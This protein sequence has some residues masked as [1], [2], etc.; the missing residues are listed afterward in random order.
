MFYCVLYTLGC[1]GKLSDRHKL[2]HIALL[3]SS[4]PGWAP[5]LWRWMWKLRVLLKLHVFTHQLCWSRGNVRPIHKDSDLIDRRTL[6][7]SLWIVAWS[8]L[9]NGCM[10]LFLF[11]VLTDL[12]SC[13]VVWSSTPTSQLQDI[14][15]SLFFFCQTHW[16]N[17]LQ[18]TRVISSLSA[19]SCRLCSFMCETPVTAGCFI[20][21]G[22]TTSNLASNQTV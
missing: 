22:L 7:V 8:R 20:C 6:R 2:L 15:N 11:S 1:S 4:R 13:A 19:V 14:W 12:V 17:L 9:R 10:I 16:L 18:I 5:F 3:N 21:T